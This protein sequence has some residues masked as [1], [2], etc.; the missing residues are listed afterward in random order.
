[1]F[2]RL[3]L[4]RVT[5]G[6]THLGKRESANAALADAMITGPFR[7][8]DTS[9]AYAAGQSEQ[10]LGDAI[11]RAGGLPADTVVF[12]KVD[13]DPD[14]GTFDGDRVLRSFEESISRLGVD[15]L[16]LLHLHDPYTLTVSEAMGPAGAVP[17]LLKLKEQGLVE[18][19]GI[20]AG[21]R[22]VVEEYMRTDAFDAVLTH[23][24]YSLV[25]RSG[26]TIIQLATDRSMAVFNAAPFGGG[27]LA[28]S[29]TRGQTYGYQ[30]ASPE[31]LAYIERLHALCAEHE[32]DIAAAAL[33]FS[34]REPRVHST[35]VG[36]YSMPRLEELSTLVRQQVPESLWQA[37]DALGTP[38][39]TPTD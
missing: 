28:G 2:D 39:P 34:F 30:Q 6:T 33:H 27:I 21:T 5:V 8:I 9:N 31:L 19:I 17:A 15:R 16:P 25:D 20:A 32:T 38:P 14:T 7:Q 26:E 18:A 3:S 35:V 36:V 1:M 11:R 12:T 10:F 23:N 13:Q 37:I 29:D 24:R 4:D 22:A